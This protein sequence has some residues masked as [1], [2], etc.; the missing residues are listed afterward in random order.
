MLN[1]RYLHK[2]LFSNLQYI[3][4]VEISIFCITI[5]AQPI[6]YSRQVFRDEKIKNVPFSLVEVR[7]RINRTTR[8]GITTPPPPRWRWLGDA[9]LSQRRRS[10]H[11]LRP[12]DPAP[13]SIPSSIH[14]VELRMRTTFTLVQHQNRREGLQEPLHHWGTAV[15]IILL[16]A[17]WI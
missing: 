6:T 16:S 17:H 11:S 7:K 8:E 15:G 4:M 13:K 3:Y 10:S 14:R 12:A 2:V 5:N 9:G 1:S